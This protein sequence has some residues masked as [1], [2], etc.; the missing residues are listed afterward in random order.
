VIAERAMLY[1]IVCAKSCS[2]FLLAGFE[3]RGKRG[4]NSR[5]KEV[6][7]YIYLFQSYSGVEG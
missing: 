5:R 7:K 6:L 3:G 4:I 2:F 1:P